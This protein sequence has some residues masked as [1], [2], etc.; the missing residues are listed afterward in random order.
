MGEF[1]MGV[2]VDSVYYCKALLNRLAMNVA[3][4]AETRGGARLY[5]TLLFEWFAPAD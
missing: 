4:V 5:T 1:T 2:P 3:G